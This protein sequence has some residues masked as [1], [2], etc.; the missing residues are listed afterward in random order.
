MVKEFAARGEWD[1][2]ERIIQFLGQEFALS[3]NP[4]SR[5][6]GLLALA[7]SA[8]ALGRDSQRY[9]SL[10]V[11]PVLACF[12]DSDGNVRFFA[13]QSLYNIAKVARDAVL[14]HFTDIFNGISRLAADPE[15]QVKNGSE[16]LDRVMKVSILCPRLGAECIGRSHG[17]PERL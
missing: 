8:V 2:I 3:Q 11:H 13:C 17:C 1:Q 12:A 6:G 9:I 5:K 15:L 4:H 10:L 7:S 16:V 14:T